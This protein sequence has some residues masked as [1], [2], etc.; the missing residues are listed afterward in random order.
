MSN[1]FITKSII[2]NPIGVIELNPD[3]TEGLADLD[4]FSHLIL[5]YHLHEVDGFKPTMKPFTDDK[6]H[7]VFATRSPKRPSAIGISM[8]KLVRVTDNKVYFGGADM[9]NETPLID[10][11][12]F[13]RQTDNRTDAIS[14]WLDEKNDLRAHRHRSDDRFK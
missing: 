2:V 1:D 8:V 7:G 4:G 11:K 10:I 12:P 6:I 14:G 5:I 9:L 13:F 3:S